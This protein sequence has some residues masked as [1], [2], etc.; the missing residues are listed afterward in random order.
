MIFLFLC[1]TDWWQ[2]LIH[3]VAKRSFLT[4]DDSVNGKIVEN[5]L[6]QMKK[7][8]KFIEV[9]WEERKL[10]INSAACKAKKKYKFI[11]DIR[12]VSERRA[13]KAAEEKMLNEFPLSIQWKMSEPKI[14]IYRFAIRLCLT[15]II[16]RD[17]DF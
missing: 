6:F 7:Q 10:F 4:D 9:G 2:S 8:K 13:E 3:S 12:V 15:L 5:S 1:K 14:R 17:H 16:I 11:Q